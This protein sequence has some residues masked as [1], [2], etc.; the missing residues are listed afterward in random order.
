M[1]HKLGAN[2]RPAAPHARNKPVL[3]SGIHGPICPWRL[4]IQVAD[5]NHIDGPWRHLL[6]RIYPSVGSR[7]TSYTLVASSRFV[8][9]SF[10]RE[11]RC[12]CVVHFASPLLSAST[13]IVRRQLWRAS[14]ESSLAAARCRVARAMLRNHGRRDKRD[15][16][17]VAAKL[18]TKSQARRC[19]SSRPRAGG[20]AG[21]GIPTTAGL[22]RSWWRWA[23]GSV[24]SARNCRA[25][26]A[27]QSTGHRIAVVGAVHEV[28]ETCQL[29]EPLWLLKISSQLRPLP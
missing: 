2:S 8:E 27:V 19:N 4:G 22:R 1:Q 10:C 29:L 17:A 24:R 18:L 14:C 26:A 28:C 5:A 16:L 25:A 6:R 9:R 20:R 3:V 23:P 11:S 7:K 21:F 13:V 15:T 12:S